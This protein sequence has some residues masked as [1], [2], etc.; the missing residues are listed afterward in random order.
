M[1][2]VLILLIG[3]LTT[4]KA[5]ACQCIPLT[6]DEEVKNSNS[7]FHGRVVSAD[8]YKFEIEIIQLWKGDFKLKVFQLTQGRTSCER[9]TFEL[10]KEYLFYLRD[11]S[12]FNC[13]RTEEFNLT[14][15]TEL[16][17]LTFNH[18]GDRA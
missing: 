4:T 18:V 8:N 7:I 5:Q 17:D 16:L 3:L 2:V 10:N 12:I 6:F 15:D 11:N 13:S 14:T 1:R 9:R